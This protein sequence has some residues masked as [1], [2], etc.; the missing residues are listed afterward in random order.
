MGAISTL[1]MALPLPTASKEPLRTHLGDDPCPPSLP[2]LLYVPPRP[3]P[4]PQPSC[5]IRTSGGGRR[6]KP[7]WSRHW[8]RTSG[9][10]P[11]TPSPTG[12]PPWG[13]TLR[14]PQSPPLHA[15][16]TAVASLE[17]LGLA[18]SATGVEVS[19]PMLS[20]LTVVEAFQIFT[21]DLA[22]YSS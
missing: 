4:R 19:N 8:R 13:S 18:E 2:S 15:T 10:L 7:T 6:V 9:S 14:P 17:R 12:S 22:R 1:Q 16:L 3:L 11:W 5:S 21:G 20:D